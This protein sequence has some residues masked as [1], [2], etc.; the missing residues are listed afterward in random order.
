MA[1]IKLELTVQGTDRTEMEESAWNIAGQYFG[2]DE[3]EIVS[4]SNARYVD[5]RSDYAASYNIGPSGFEADFTFKAI[6]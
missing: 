1:T 6:L 5:M 2:E 3:Y 4:S